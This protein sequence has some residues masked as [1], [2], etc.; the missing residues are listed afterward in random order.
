[1]Y[2]EALQAAWEEL[3]APGGPF[4]TVPVTVCGRSLQAYRHAPDH[5]GAVWQ[6]TMAFSKRD[7]IVF[8][9]ERI[10]YDQAHATCARIQGWLRARGIQA[11]DRVAIAMR[12]LPEWM[13]IYWSCTSM[14]VVIVALNSWWSGPELA[15]ALKHAEPKILFADVDRL[16]RLGF[17]ADLL[18]GT[19]AVAV[20][21]GD[22]RL[23]GCVD[24]DEVTRGPAESMI[25]DADSEAAAC[26]LYTSGTSGSAKG[27]VLSHRGCTNNIMNVL[28]AGR[29]QALA[30]KRAAS[31][32][33][34]AAIP[35]DPPVVLLT[36]PLFHVTA[37]NCAAQIATILG[38]RIV[39]MPRWDAANALKLVESERV[40]TMSGVPTMSRELIS[41]PDF[42]GRD[43][44]SLTALAGGGAPLQPDILERIERRGGDI[45]VS[46]GYGMTEAS[47]VIASN[48]GAFLKLKPHSCGPLL[49]TYKARFVGDNGGDVPHS[50]AGELWLQGVTVITEY[51][52]QQAATEEAVAD[53]WL[54]TGDIARL[55]VDGFL[56]IV[57]RKKEMILRGGENVYCV[58]V[59][60]M[61]SLHPDVLECCAFAVA[62]ERL[63]E[64][65]GAAVLLRDGA[66]TTVED[67]L[68]HCREGLAGYKVP[69]HLWLLSEPIPRNASGKYLKTVLRESL[70]GASPPAHVRK[71]P[72]GVG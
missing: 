59:E 22:N 52:R 65:V 60:A 11:G 49:P 71:S 20:R 61:L 66:A 36:T 62:N 57:D 14:G 35:Q 72:G 64:T 31:I 47:G 24:W 54:R 58:E 39:L 45:S 55:D 7:Y 42:V 56:H 15:A 23:S 5:L 40:T 44:S 46:S 19:V 26:I 30:A 2:I 32:D 25:Y 21:A 12:N 1:M 37:N 48:G 70:T 16:N 27:A 67:I 3:T 51:F 6:S 8:E 9:D 63:G 13:L 17:G 28:F 69:E 43:T 50:A 29:V 41:H 10:T 53:G 33:D 4:E 68:V 18:P 38:G 34:G